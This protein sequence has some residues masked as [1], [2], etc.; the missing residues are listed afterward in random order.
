[1][2]K[3]EH[4]LSELGFRQNRNNN[5]SRNFDIIQ[6]VRF[7]ER[8]SVRVTWKEEW[9]NYFAIIFDYTEA[10]GP[11]CVVPTKVL[12]NS[13][14]VFRKRHERS[15]INSG[16]YWSQLFFLNDDL[17][18]LVLS[19]ADRWDI[20]AA[21][22]SKSVSRPPF[23]KQVPATKLTAKEKPTEIES[24]E[25]QSANFQSILRALS[26]DNLLRLYYD[27]NEELHERKIKVKK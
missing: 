8:S 25:Q 10:S 22:E 20:L 1:M 4:K 17:P 23:C 19:Y 7:S 13:P 16:N 14:F 2:N 21:S 3:L 5:W 11:I 6:V 12:F 15:Y 24:E 9:K 27:I 18:Q 26:D